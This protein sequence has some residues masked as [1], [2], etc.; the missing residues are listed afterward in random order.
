M[1]KISNPIIVG[2][3][4]AS[5]EIKK[6]RQ[7]YTCCY[8]GEPI[9]KGTSYI[10]HT[11][12]DKEGLKH[13]KAH[14]SCENC[15]KNLNTYIKNSPYITSLTSS[16]YLIQRKFI[17]AISKFFY[18]FICPECPTENE[19][20]NNCLYRGL[21]TKIS[22][23]HKLFK[24]KELVTLSDG[25]MKLIDRKPVIKCNCCGKHITGISTN[26]FAHDGS[27]FDTI[28]PF[29][30]TTDTYTKMIV[31]TFWCGDDLTT[32]ERREIISCP[33][34]GKFPFPDKDIQ[35]YRVLEIVCFNEQLPGAEI[36]D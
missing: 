26:F 29:K 22:E 5:K 33:H 2:K 24:N 34:C 19:C 10:D 11:V 17:Y 9:E 35:I 32:S 28:V 16:D 27:D 36:S 13:Y 31:P 30:E 8:C 4:F 3:F 14:I 15:V 7:E 23:I 18:E 25:C 20:N 1:N 21:R 6:S 12:Q